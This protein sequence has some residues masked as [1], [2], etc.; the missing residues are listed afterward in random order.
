MS[1]TGGE[2][3]L[4][5]FK[6]CRKVSGTDQIVALRAQERVLCDLDAVEYSEAYRNNPVDQRGNSVQLDQEVTEMVQDNLMFRAMV[7]GFNYKANLLRTA[8]GR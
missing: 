4:Y 8:M 5:L 3:A 2:M 1:L 6:L 7:N